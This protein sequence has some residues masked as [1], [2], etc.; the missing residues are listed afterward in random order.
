MAAK[1]GTYTLINSSVLTGN[2][3]SVTFSSI[4]AT[5]TDLI[6]VM[7]II[8]NAGQQIYYQINGDTATNYSGTYLS[9]NGT[10]ATSARFTSQ[11]VAPVGIVPNTSTTNPNFNAI[12]NFQD[13]SNTTTYKTAISRANN[14]SNGVEATASLWRSTAAINSININSSTSSFAA[15]SIFKLYGIEAAK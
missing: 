10:S 13:Y 5:Y 14:A 4:P 9:G 1:T 2:T 12:I 7:N 3:G 11:T 15:G 8:G 6:F